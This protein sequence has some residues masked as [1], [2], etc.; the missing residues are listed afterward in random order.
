[1][2]TIVLV[3]FYSNKRKI[4]FDRCGGEPTVAALREQFFKTFE[5]VI[6]E[7]I[8]PDEILFQRFSKKHNDWIDLD[9]K[10]RVKNKDKIRAQIKVSINPPHPVK[11]TKAY[12]L[13]NPSSR[14]NGSL[15]KK[16]TNPS[17]LKCDGHNSDPP[18]DL[19]I[20]F[21]DESTLETPKLF[22]LQFDGSTDTDKWLITGEGEHKD[23]SVKPFDTKTGTVQKNQKFQPSYF[24]GSTRF[25]CL[26]VGG[27][28]DLFLSVESDGKVTLAEGGPIEYPV[29]STLF[30]TN[31]Q[32]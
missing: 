6:P 21:I 28:N 16:T 15:L 9:D 1:M 20:Q 22:R 17:T 24:F 11:N 25:E 4:E 14:V 29:A 10:D 19:K 26:D 30:V 12:R 18:A 31:E 8:T 7:G 32:P 2:P 5:N 23:V 27:R 3:T 13:W